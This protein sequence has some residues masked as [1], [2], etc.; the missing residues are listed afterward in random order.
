MDTITMEQGFVE[1]IHKEKKWTL[2]CCC[3]V[4]KFFEKLIEKT[5]INR[6]EDPCAVCFQI[7]LLHH[8]NTILCFKLPDEL[9]E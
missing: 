3:S 5:P 4:K 8:S 2:L 1:F 7:Q 9:T 6:S